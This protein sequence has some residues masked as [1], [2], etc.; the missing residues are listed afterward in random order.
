MATGAEFVG[1]IG[2]WSSDGDEMVVRRSAFGG[3]IELETRHGPGPVIATANQPLGDGPALRM[4]A[5]PALDV[6]AVPMGSGETA[7]EGARLVVSGGRG[8]DEEDFRTLRALATA[9]AARLAG[10]FRQSISGSSRCRG[11]SA[12]R[13]SSSLRQSISRSACR[14]R[15]SI[16]PESAPATRIIAINKDQSAPIFR[17]A[18][19]GAVA[20]AKIL[21]PRLLAALSKGHAHV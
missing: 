4:A 15:R 19:A 12:S 1:R 11:R 17:F 13:A 8:L 6:E 20:D 7:L 16:S 9:S 2:S 18:E 21:L 14:A 5:P 10:R 3:R